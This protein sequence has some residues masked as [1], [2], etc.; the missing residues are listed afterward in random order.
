MRLPDNLAALERCWFR[1]HRHQ[2]IPAPPLRQA[3]PLVVLLLR[4][5]RSKARRKGALQ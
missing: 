1:R 5:R 2:A 4:T 3:T